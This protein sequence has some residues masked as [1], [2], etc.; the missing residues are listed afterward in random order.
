MFGPRWESLRKAKRFSL[1]AFC[2]LVLAIKR[3]F[4]HFIHFGPSPWRGG[5]E[6]V[7][8]L[9]WVR[10]EDVLKAFRARKRGALVLHCGAGR[11]RDGSRAV[12]N[13]ESGV[14]VESFDAF[15]ELRMEGMS[16][17]KSKR[18]P[19]ARFKRTF[20]R[21][22]LPLQQKDAGESSSCLS[23]LS[24]ESRREK[25]SLRFQSFPSCLVMQPLD[26]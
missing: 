7:W 6:T 13:R 9:Y 20:S 18:R 3:F 4:G 25:A 10:S 23:K 5:P 19:G 24:Q 17:P 14:Q 26:A 21:S 11:G 15:L 2:R 1:F 8:E 22:R 12:S 16:S